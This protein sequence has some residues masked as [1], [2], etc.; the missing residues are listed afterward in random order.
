MSGL[1]KARW[2]GNV[3]DRVGLGKG[4]RSTRR[5]LKRGTGVKGFGGLWSRL[6]TGWYLKVTVE[7]VVRLVAEIN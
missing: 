7:E 2:V 1:G 5:V 4:N 6:E 3:E